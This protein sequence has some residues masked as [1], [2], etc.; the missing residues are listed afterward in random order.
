MYRT[1]QTINSAQ[2]QRVTSR[3]DVELQS[4]E[5]LNRQVRLITPIYEHPS[6]EDKCS[7]N[8]FN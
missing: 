2:I 7:L 3:N 5:Q 6:Y 4:N 1:I 8:S